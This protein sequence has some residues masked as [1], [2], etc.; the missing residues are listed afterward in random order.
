MKEAIFHE[1]DRVIYVPNH[2]A[3][4]HLHQDCERGTIVTLGEYVAYCTFEYPNG[5][6]R[7]TAN[8][9][10]TPIEN[11]VHDERPLHIFEITDPK[12]R[13]ASII[14]AIGQ[15][16]EDVQVRCHLHLFTTSP[17]QPM[18]THL[19]RAGD[20]LDA[21]QR[22]AS[23]LKNIKREGGRIVLKELA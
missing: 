10:A 12:E 5:E 18:R 3:G 1:G 8:A 11:L 9:E 16:V 15:L 22:A 23:C 13:P 6:L 2:A 4:N 7:T 17:R 14:D 20:V 19:I 21:R